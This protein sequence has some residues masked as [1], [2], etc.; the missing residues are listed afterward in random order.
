[1]DPFSLIVITGVVLVDAKS[2][3]DDLTDNLVNHEH[4]NS[5][6]QD[7]PAERQQ[8]K[9]KHEES[10]VTV[11]ILLRICKLNEVNLVCI[12]QSLA[13]IVHDVGTEDS[14]QRLWPDPVSKDP[15]GDGDQPHND[16][17]H[18]DDVVEEVTAELTE[19]A[20]HVM[21][22]PPTLTDATS[23]LVDRDPQ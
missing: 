14:V 5:S 22:T 1:M 9:S 4:E 11:R 16:E 18:G 23:E 21:T 17:G 12:T 13:E 20:S 6:E 10:L 15:P 8:E 19:A 2:A 7:N 3:A